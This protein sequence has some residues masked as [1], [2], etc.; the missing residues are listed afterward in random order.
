MI[1]VSKIFRINGKVLK[2]VIV[3]LEF[4]DHSQLEAFRVKFKELENLSEVRFEYCDYNTRYCSKCGN[5][6]YFDL[7]KNKYVCECNDKN[8]C[9]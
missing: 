9:S 1:R 2:P 4:S 5:Q 8:M 6:M 3:N 7:E